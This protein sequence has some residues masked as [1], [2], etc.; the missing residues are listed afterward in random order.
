M[1]KELIDEIVTRKKKN[2]IENKMQELLLKSEGNNTRKC[3]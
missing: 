1:L 3:Y 2:D